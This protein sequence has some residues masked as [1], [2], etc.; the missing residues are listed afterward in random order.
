M[1][2]YNESAAK[3]LR[4]PALVR[5]LQSK[6][7]EVSPELRQQ[8]LVKDLSEQLTGIEKLVSFPQGKV[9]TQEDVRKVNDAVNRVMAEIESK[10][11]AK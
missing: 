11:P 8:P 1:K 4:Q 2:N 3:V 9:P 6:L 7:N 10:E 5:F